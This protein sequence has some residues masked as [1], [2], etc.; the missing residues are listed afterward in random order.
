V[1]ASA[2][3]LIK[4]LVVGGEPTGLPGALSL[5][6]LAGSRPPDPARARRCVI[7]GEA[8]DPAARE[9]DDSL[10][11]GAATGMRHR[12]AARQA[13]GARDAYTLDWTPLPDAAAGE[14]AGPPASWA[15]L[16]SH[17][18]AL[19][20]AAHAAGITAT[21]YTDIAALA[22]CLNDSAP[23]PDLILVAA[24]TVGKGT[25]AGRHPDPGLPDRLTAVT[26]Q[27]LGVVKDWLAQGRLA[28]TPLVIIT[29]GAVSTGT[30]DDLTGLAAA[31]V[32]GLIRS[33]QAGHPGRITLADTDGQDASAAA[34]P[35][36]ITA[37]RAAEEPQVAIRNGTAYVP[38][39]AGIGARSRRAGLDGGL[40]FPDAPG[41]RL[42]RVRRGT[43]DGLA[44]L[45]SDDM[46]AP[47]AAGQVR[48]AL[49]AAG[50]DFHD[51]AVALDMVAYQ[52]ATFGEG[53]GVVTAV[54]PDVTGLAPG[55]RVTGLFPHIASEAVTDARLLMPV[56]AD[57]SYAQAAT[58]PVAFLTAWRGLADLARLAPGQKLLLHA[59]TGGVGQ[60]ALQI[61]RH[62]GAQVY[63]T[64][65]PQKHATL[66]A[67]GVPPDRIASSRSPAFEAAFAQA[68]GGTG[69]HV[70]LNCLTGDL[71]DASLRLLPRGGHFIELG[72]T[73]L[74]HPD[75]VAAAHP[76]VIYQAFD[77][78]GT[79]P[80]HIGQILA[81]LH[82]LFTRGAL[83]PLPVADFDIRRA[84]AA[85]RHLA[86][87]RHTS[88]ILLTI[89]PA[90]AHG[91]TLITGGTGTLAAATARRLVTSH[92]ARHLLLASR[93]G[94]DAP[95]ATAVAEELAAFGAQ[96]TITA[97]D[98]SDRYA[99]AELLDSIPASRPLAAVIH[100]AVIDTGVDRTAVV[101]DDGII[102]SLTP[103][104][105]AP[106]LAAK[107][108]TA[109]YLHELTAEADLAAFILYSSAAGISGSPGAGSVAAAGSFLDALAAY[110]H[111]RG[112]PAASLAG[113]AVALLDT[114]LAAGRPA[115][116]HARLIIAP[117]SGGA[118]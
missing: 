73:D 20:T 31:G 18:P 89:P 104:R 99:L 24:H 63:A 37:A 107:A 6:A 81:T 61:A 70:V 110:R 96:V 16:G 29:R 50:V 68:T 90:L 112:L 118:E 65:S 39:L 105:L 67:L 40:V 42:D 108:A 56:P 30:G 35:A 4:P 116:I 62:F 117:G 93:R 46:G 72:K 9:L 19:V 12:L 114:A 60:A 13:R 27:V 111:A 95:G 69:M 82:G 57:W 3:A 47:L 21:G 74:R 86:Q 80:D 25:P 23:P 102:T 38:R 106:V 7:T 15:L 33:A 79:G 64:A 54:G 11:E 32:W 78:M 45:P 113:D 26:G 58:V 52:R 5:N 14:P 51:V 103:A 49:H 43:F 59:A 94:Q 53:A 66:Q 77:I 101:D 71:L 2:D 1:T 55:D 10:R 44:L 41:W 85:L 100:T 92:H 109:W 84:P 48:V 88:K 83:A 8:G 22:A 28:S 76:G 34:L 17:D 97:C 75:A 115:G 98:T 91:T 36:A 87:A